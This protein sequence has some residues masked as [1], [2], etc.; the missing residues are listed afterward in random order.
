MVRLSR[1]YIIT[2]LYKQSDIVQMGFLDHVR[3]YGH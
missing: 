2:S 3:M 1:F